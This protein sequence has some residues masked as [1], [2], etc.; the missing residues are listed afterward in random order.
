MFRRFAVAFAAVATLA[1]AAHA[2]PVTLRIDPS[3][4]HV[5][6]TVPH[7][8][9]SITY[10]RF[11]DVKGQIVFD[12]DNVSAS[13]ITATIQTKS[14][15]TNFPA[16]DTH[17]KSADFFDVEKHPTMTFVSTG[18]EKTGDNTGR[19]TGNLTM[20][21]VTKPVTLDV[22]FTRMAEQP[23]PAYKKVLTAG[24]SAQGKVKR[25]DFGMTKFLPAIP[26]EIDIVINLEGARCEGEGAEAPSCK[27]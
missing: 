21:G 5:G 7:L 12:K 27:S 11:N 20:L 19:L 9:Y 17:L 15:D 8:G 18:I 2:E 22:K 6:F 26:D 1:T 4:M 16:R 25:S 13:K 24:F 14:L 23:L 3:H 10:G